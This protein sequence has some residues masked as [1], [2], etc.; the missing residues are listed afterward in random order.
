[1]TLPDRFFLTAFVFYCT[2][3][4]TLLLV[5]PWSAGWDRMVSHLPE[6][7]KFFGALPVRAGLSGFGLVHLVWCVHDLHLL[8]MQ[9]SSRTPPV[10]TTSPPSESS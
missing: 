9:A 6:F 5:L 7:L 8:L 3:I 2:L 1:M 10:S 4:G